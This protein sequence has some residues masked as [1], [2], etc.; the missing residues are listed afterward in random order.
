MRGLFGLFEIYA[1]DLRERYGGVR[2]SIK[3]DDSA[4]SLAMDVKLQDTDWHKKTA[5]DMYKIDK[6]KKLSASK[7]APKVSDKSNRERSKIFMSN[8]TE[9]EYSVVQIEGEEEENGRPDDSEER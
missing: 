6:K 9:N 3:F 7:Q 8:E 4:R 1:A 5:E 2:R